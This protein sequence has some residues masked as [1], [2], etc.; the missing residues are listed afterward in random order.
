MLS[1]LSSFCTERKKSCQYKQL[2]SCSVRTFTVPPPATVSSF[3][4][5]SC[6][7]APSLRV[8]AF[9]YGM[10]HTALHY[11]IL[12][13]SNGSK[14]NWPIAFTLHY[15]SQQ[16]FNENQELM[17]MV[18]VNKCS[19]LNYRMPYKQIRQLAYNYGRRMQCK[20]PSSWIDNKTAGIDW[21]QGFMKQ[22][23]NLTLHQ[24]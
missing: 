5:F 4:Q 9:R 16:I 3:Q 23:K 1:L 22:H 11:R 8:A 12:K 15:M 20:F 18:Y 7:C 17:L 13:I 24:P 21:L 19:K 6:Q 2:C 10:T 14:C